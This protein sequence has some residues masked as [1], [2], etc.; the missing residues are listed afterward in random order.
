MTTL[1]VR[2]A[3]YQR[4]LNE[5]PASEQQLNELSRGYE[6]S[7]ANYDEL[8]KKENE[9]RMATSMEQ[10]QQG[11]R[12]TILDPPS[13]PLKPDSPKRLLLCGVGLVF[14]LILGVLT[15]SGLEFFD[16]RIYSDKEIKALLPVAVLSEVPV[17]STLED[18]RRVHRKTFLGWAMTA[19][20]TVCILV[21][22]AFSYLRS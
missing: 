19:A 20:V 6:Q 17:V 18:E 22:C 13:L 21:G 14:G 10:L 9:S 8:L 7:K 5:G 15:V 11:E 2:I 1:G 12:F 3:D 4:R 16:D